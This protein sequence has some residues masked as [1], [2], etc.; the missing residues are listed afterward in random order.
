MAEEEQTEEQTEESAEGKKS[1]GSNLILIIV[2]VVLILVILIG[3]FAFILMSGGDEGQQP[4]QQQQQ[5][6]G[7]VQQQ[8]NQRPG[9]AIML[10]VGPMFPLNTFTVNLSSDS[11]RRYLKVEMNLELSGE[12]LGMELE[13]K[14]AVVRDT[15]IRLLSSKSFEEISTEK[16]KDKLKEQIVDQLNLRLK[17]GRV[18][19]VYFVEFVVQ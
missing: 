12:E 14:T 6:Q 16:G 1:G 11:G 2:I 8:N 18:V 5:Q 10:E 13:Q 4:Q 15:V 9:Q 3:I 19:N 17:D 7:Q